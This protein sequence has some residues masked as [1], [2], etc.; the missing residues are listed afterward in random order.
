M[1]K[2]RKVPKK[3]VIELPC[4]PAIPLLGDI[5]VNKIDIDLCPHRVDMLGEGTDTKHTRRIHFKHMVLQIF[6]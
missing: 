3:N 6:Q 4:D 1:G 2:S 5:V